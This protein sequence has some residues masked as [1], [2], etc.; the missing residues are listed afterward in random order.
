MLLIA[1]DSSSISSRPKPGAIATGLARSPREISSAERE[2]T[3]TRVKRASRYGSAV[4]SPSVITPAHA[5]FVHIGWESR[6]WKAASRAPPQTRYPVK[7]FR[8]SETCIPAPRSSLGGS[9]SR[10]SGLRLALKAG[11]SSWIGRRTCGPGELVGVWKD[12]WRRILLV[13]RLAGAPRRNDRSPEAARRS[14][15]GAK[16]TEPG[17]LQ[18][19]I[20]PE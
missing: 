10:R 20:L 19:G 13:N 7:I 1:L 3:R 4:A 5:A 17:R 9:Q 15:L 11:S 8:C 2:R 16:Q 18:S 12:L 6:S 14:F